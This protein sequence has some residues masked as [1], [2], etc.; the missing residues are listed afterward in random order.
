M[1]FK[2]KDK[3]LQQNMSIIINVQ[4]IEQVKYTKFLGLYI[5]EELSW[6]Y[7][8]N[9]VTMK[10]SKLTGIMAKARHYVTVKTL[11]NIDS[12]TSIKRTELTIV[13]LDYV[14]EIRIVV[15]LKR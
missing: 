2:A 12:E 6:K 15:D 4:Q 13:A 9:H 14:L 3:K 7:H 1:I 8:I 11:Q 10:I 5:D